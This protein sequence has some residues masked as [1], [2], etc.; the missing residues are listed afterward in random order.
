MRIAQ[1]ILPM[2]SIFKILAFV[3]VSIAF[4]PAQDA[5]ARNSDGQY[6]DLIARHCTVVARDRS[7]R[8][9]EAPGYIHSQTVRVQDVRSLSRRWVRAYATVQ[10]SGRVA[11]GHMDYNTRTGQVRCP[12]GSFIYN[13]FPLWELLRNW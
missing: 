5:A 11:V 6:R 9:T 3:L 12:P 13:H 10:S 4:S 7:E 8:Y 2:K 1:G